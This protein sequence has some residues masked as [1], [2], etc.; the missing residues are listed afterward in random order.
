V[1]AAELDLAHFDSSPAFDGHLCHHQEY[2]GLQVPRLHCPSAGIFP[3]QV[4]RHPE[5]G[6]VREQCA[7]RVVES[8]GGAAGISTLQEIISKVDF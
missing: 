7:Q 4:L 1:K 6:S 2:Q 3:V 8:F 5:P